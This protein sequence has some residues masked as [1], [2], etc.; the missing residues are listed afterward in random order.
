MRE[1][2]RAEQGCKSTFTT[3]E[4][5]PI[6]DHVRA[7]MLAILHFNLPPSERICTTSYQEKKE[8]KGKR[9][10]E[11]EEANIKV[12]TGRTEHTHIYFSCYLLH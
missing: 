12:L 3:V 8:K 5:V 1:R 10:R 11:R 6:D 7:P 2:E 4:P 9:E